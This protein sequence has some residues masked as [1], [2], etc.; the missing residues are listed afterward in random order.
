MFASAR[1]PDDDRGEPRR[2]TI[3]AWCGR[4][5]EGGRWEDEAEVVAHESELAGSSSICPR[6]FDRLAPGV[7]YPEQR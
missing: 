3:C 6:C 5:A 1:R 2:V 7:P 4:R